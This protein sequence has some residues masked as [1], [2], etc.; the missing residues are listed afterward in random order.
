MLKNIGHAT[1]FCVHLAGNLVEWFDF[2]VME[3]YLMIIS[4]GK[5][6]W[7]RIFASCLPQSIEG[8]VQSYL[9]NLRGFWL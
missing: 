7:R 5:I 3:S 9:R 4:G 1:F 8:G 2:L 6:R